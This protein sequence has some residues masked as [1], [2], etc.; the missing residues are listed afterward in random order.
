MCPL[1]VMFR[2]HFVIRLDYAANSLTGIATC[3]VGKLWAAKESKTTQNCR[4]NGAASLDSILRM[5]A[6]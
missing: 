5:E 1:I 6:S 3:K 2:R 4:V